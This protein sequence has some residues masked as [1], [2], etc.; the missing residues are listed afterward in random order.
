MS[1]QWLPNHRIVLPKLDYRITEL[2]CPIKSV[3]LT[4]AS[5]RTDSKQFRSAYRISAEWES[6]D[7]S[8]HV[9]PIY[10]PNIRQYKPSVPTKILP[11]NH[12]CKSH[13][14]GKGKLFSVTG[15]L[16]QN[17]SLWTALCLHFLPTRHYGSSKASVAITKEFVIRW[18]LRH[19]LLN[20]WS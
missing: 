11:K 10:L 1:A 19:M 15:T 12:E 18:Q 3:C 17:R 4:T 7:F 5:Y 9:C 8:S 13:A 2:Y 20:S 14:S 6:R 16:T